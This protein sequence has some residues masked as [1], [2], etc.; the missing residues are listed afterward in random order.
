MNKKRILIGITTA[1]TVAH[2]V[3]QS[4]YELDI[5]EDVET[6]LKIVHAYNVADGRNNLVNIMYQENCDYLF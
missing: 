2:E 1:E 4:I 5:P 6:I 3:M